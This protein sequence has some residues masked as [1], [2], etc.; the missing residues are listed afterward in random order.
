MLIIEKEKKLTRFMSR[1]LHYNPYLQLNP[2]N[3]WKKIK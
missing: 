1:I 2:F 3:E